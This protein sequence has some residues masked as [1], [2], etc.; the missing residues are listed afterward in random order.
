MISE[1]RKFGL[2][3]LLC[4]FNKDFSKILLLKRN[5]E[6]RMKNKADWG[7]VGGKMNP[8]EKIVQACIRE[9][10]EEIGLNFSE[11]NLK[12]IEIKETPFLTDIF[13]AV[14]FVYATVLEENAKI[15]INEESEEYKW[16]SLENIPEKTLD[17]KED[18]IR[19]S[20]LAKDKF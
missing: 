4:I 5:K 16:F 12:L 2:G 15:C 11:N 18:I 14:H 8:G 1:D 17:T 7:M 20:Q 13:H 3:V 19:L 6:K 10:Q 9:A